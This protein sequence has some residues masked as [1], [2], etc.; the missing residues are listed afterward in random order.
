MNFAGH[1]RW[2]D[3]A[4]RTRC[5]VE[6][7]VDAVA[8]GRCRLEKLTEVVTPFTKSF[9]SELNEASSFTTSRFVSLLQSFAAAVCLHFEL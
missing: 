9:R 7:T 8:Q 2:L 4:A 1:R 3:A 5:S 6:E